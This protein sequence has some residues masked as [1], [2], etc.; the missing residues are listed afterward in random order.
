[1]TRSLSSLAALVLLAAPASAQR[2]DEPMADASASEREHHAHSTPEVRALYA[3]LL[4]GGL[5][6]YTRHE[7]TDMRA[8][9]R[10]P[11]DLADCTTQRN[12][13]VAGVS[14]AKEVGENLRDLGVPVG[15]VYASP[16]CRTRETA[17]HLYGR[18]KV[19]PELYA[20][21]ATREA[22]AATLL[23]VLSRPV[24]EGENAAVVAHVSNVRALTGVMLG[25]GDTAVLDPSETDPETGAPRVLEVV[26]S[27]AWNDLALDVL[28]APC[29]ARLG[30][31]SGTD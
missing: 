18:S 16:T 22:T 19:V 6:L 2:S 15:P 1:M 4:G 21:G 5:V 11:L 20:L 3:R 8:L 12:L 31:E 10:T 30:D 27:N 26:R 23:A 17:R 29:A 13:S 24:P 28:F 14:V 25:E 9:D 7:R